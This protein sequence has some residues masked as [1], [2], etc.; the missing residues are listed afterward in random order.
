MAASSRVTPRNVLIFAGEERFAEVTKPRLESM[1]ADLRRI[2][3]VPG[4]NA[5]EDQVTVDMLGRIQATL[6]RDQPALVLMDPIQCFLPPG[7]DMNLMTDTRAALNP[8][9]RL[10]ATYETTIV[11]IR[12]H[13]KGTG[14][15]RQMASGS[16]DITGCMISSLIEAEPDNPREADEGIRFVGHSKSNLA[17]EGP[18]LAFALVNREGQPP[19]FRWTGARKG[20]RADSLTA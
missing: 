5:N 15:A 12:H 6:E 14:K 10:A 11:F 20:L 17:P 8:L 1:G 7:C 2:V 3:Y 18:V 4:A 13:R 9:R 16:N 19:S